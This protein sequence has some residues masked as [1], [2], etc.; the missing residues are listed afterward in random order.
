[1]YNNFA[2]DTFKGNNIWHFT[3]IVNL[4]LKS[5]ISTLLSKGIEVR[6]ENLTRGNSFRVK[7]GLCVLDGGKKIFIDRRMPESEQIRFLSELV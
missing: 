3:V 7:S 2:A 4:K 5:L 6:R 1:L